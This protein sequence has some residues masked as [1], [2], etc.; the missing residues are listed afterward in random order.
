MLMAMSVE[1]CYQF[2]QGS[3]WD[4][5]ASFQNLEESRMCLWLAEQ[6]LKATFQHKIGKYSEIYC[7]VQTCNH[8]GFTMQRG[9]RKQVKNKHR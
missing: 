2:L 4:W 6:S 3:S 9:C 8:Y 1:G 7:L 5:A